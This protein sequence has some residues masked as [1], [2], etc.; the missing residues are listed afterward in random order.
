[1]KFRIADSVSNIIVVLDDSKKFKIGLYKDSSSA[2]GYDFDT[3]PRLSDEYE[4]EYLVK[5]IL[6][7]DKKIYRAFVYAILEEKITNI[8]K[9]LE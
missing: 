9:L 1:M 7:A 6:D 4:K 3:I 5:N 8:E 2:S